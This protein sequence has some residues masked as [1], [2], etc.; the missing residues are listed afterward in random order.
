M[1]VSREARKAV[2]AGRQLQ[3]LDQILGMAC[4]APPVLQKCFFVN[5]EIDMFYFRQLAPM[6]RFWRGGRLDSWVLKI[7]RLAVDIADVWNGR[8]ALLVPGYN[9]LI[10]SA[11]IAHLANLASLKTLYL[12]LDHNASMQMYRLIRLMMDSELDV[13]DYEVSAQD[14]DWDEDEY[15][16]PC[17]EIGED[18]D[19]SDWLRGFP[20]DQW[21]FHNVGPESD[22]H[23]QRTLNCIIRPRAFPERIKI[24]F[25]DWLNQII[26]ATKE[27]AER[28]GKLT[29][30]IQMVMDVTGGYK[31]TNYY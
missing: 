17:F 11:T 7:E 31:R 4:P 27:D 5:W 22:L 30:D 1:Q 18:S 24:P 20:T 2:L 25:L 26:S 10:N 19:Y 15:S 9:E 6:T 29:V 16:E 21:K 14:E 3:K 12:V 8:D 13:D 23:S 28:S